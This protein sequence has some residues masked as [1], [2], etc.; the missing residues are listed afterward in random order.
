M[1]GAFLDQG[2]LFRTFPPGEAPCAR[3]AD[4]SEPQPFEAIRPLPP[5]FDA[6]EMTTFVDIVE[7]K[8]MKCLCHIKGI[9]AN[10][11]YVERFEDLAH[12]EHDFDVVT[13]L[14]SLINAPAALIKAEIDFYQEEDANE[15][16]QLRPL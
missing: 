12:L 15:Q 6:S 4:R 2:R 5:D 11:L 3:C 9:D 13:A 10:F 16:I 8:V 7:D 1:R 14:G